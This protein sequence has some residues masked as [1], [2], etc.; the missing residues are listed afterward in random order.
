M[1]P[2]GY[3]ETHDITSDGIYLLNANDCFQYSSLV[4][5]FI[6]F[7]PIKYP[8]IA[9]FF[10]NLPPFLLHYDPLLG[11]K[12]TQLTKKVLL[13]DISN[14]LMWLMLGE[15]RS[16]PIFRPKRHIPPIFY[17]FQILKAIE[18]LNPVQNM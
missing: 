12:I 16:K 8:K 1:I 2:G 10:F 18:N 15:K 11:C 17:C 14:K 9:C 7:I 6:E 5:T 13:K 4:S 3:Q